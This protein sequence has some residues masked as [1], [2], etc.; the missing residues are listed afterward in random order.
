MVH[1][2]SEHTIGFLKGCWHSIKH[3]CIWIADEQSH[4]FATYWIAACVGLHAFA[5]QCEEDEHMDG[6][7]SEYEDPF[8]A[9]GL[10]SSSSDDGDNALPLQ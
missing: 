6:D 9:E 7:G 5:M 8:I 10:L 2:R 3:L 1:I 4:K